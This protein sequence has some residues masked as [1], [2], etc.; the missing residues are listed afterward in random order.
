MSQAFEFFGLGLPGR[1]DAPT[2]SQLGFQSYAA[3]ELPP[4]AILADRYRIEASL[5]ERQDLELYR[6]T[7]LQAGGQV[8]I[9]RH[10]LR[11]EDEQAW[12]EHEIL[13]ALSHP[14]VPTAH[15]PFEH[16][17]RT[18]FVQTYLEGPT[19]RERFK[20]QQGKVLDART[21]RQVLIDALGVLAYLHERD[22]PVI[23]RDVKPAN[24]VML[25]GGGVG[26][27]DFGIARLGVPP[28]DGVDLDELT[29][30]HTVGYAPPEQMCGLE[31]HPASDLYALAA[32]IVYTSTN[33]HPVYHWNARKGRIEVPGHLKGRLAEVLAWMLAP[34]LD[35]RCPSASAALAKLA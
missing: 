33:R 11:C 1:P 34:A 27:I 19:L 3:V 14:G 17:G 26:L 22:V 24:M 29:S 18:C 31:A 10:P 21:A 8:K 20:Q 30:A 9:R 28:K 32:S 35:D 16:V 2:A 23:H 5:G 4:G 25:A 12:R 7:D 15:E 13:Q 6:A